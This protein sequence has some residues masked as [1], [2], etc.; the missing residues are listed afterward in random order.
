MVGTLRKDPGFRHGLAG[1]VSSAGRARIGHSAL[2]FVGW[3]I[4]NAAHTACIPIEHCHVYP[5]TIVRLRS[6]FHLVETELSYCRA[7]PSATSLKQIWI[8]YPCTQGRFAAFQPICRPRCRSWLSGP[9][10][11]SD[12]L[13][14]LVYPCA[15]INR[16]ASLLRDPDLQRN[17][18]L[19][20]DCAPRSSSSPVKVWANAAFTCPSGKDCHSR[21]MGWLLTPPRSG[22]PTKVHSAVVR[23]STRIAE[24]SDCSLDHASP[25][26]ISPTPDAGAIPALCPPWYGQLRSRASPPVVADHAK[27]HTLTNQTRRYAEYVISCVPVDNSLSPTIG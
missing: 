10:K 21:K 12:R 16:A 24:G 11:P 25:H 15:A 6:T 7:R 2:T 8:R 20:S 3:I 4:S 13:K 22:T 14:H 23:T 18:M 1:C 27:L 9:S 19:V 26:S 5:R 17:K